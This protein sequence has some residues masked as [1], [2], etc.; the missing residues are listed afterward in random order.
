MNPIVR[1]SV[2][3]LGEGGGGS[4]VQQG[5]RAGT[6]LREGRWPDTLEAGAGWLGGL[7]RRRGGEPLVGRGAG[8]LLDDLSEVAL[9][10]V[11][12]GRL[13]EIAGQKVVLVLV[14]WGGDGGLGDLVGELVEAEVL[15]VVRVVILAG[16]SSGGDGAGARIGGGVAAFLHLLSP[17]HWSAVV[18]TTT[19][20][21]VL[22]SCSPL[23]W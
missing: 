1:D 10:D 12:D 3:V 7:D 2:L 23:Y 8:K 6:E 4:G 16:A 13:L 14:E 5:R 17:F 18:V 20:W 15:E 22:L 19:R 11:V 9:V 21:W